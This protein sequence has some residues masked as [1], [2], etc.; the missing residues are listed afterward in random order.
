MKNEENL[1]SEI[2]KNPEKFGLIYDEFYK[3]ILNYVLKRTTNFDLSLDI[4]SEVFLKAFLNIGQFKWKGISIQNWLYRI[5]SN[6]INLFHRSKKYTPKLLNQT[7]PPGQFITFSTDME[8]EKEEAENELIRNTEF[9]QILAIIN[10]LPDKY[11]EVI[12]LKYFEKMNNREI[13]EILGKK[14]GTIKSL[15]SRGLEKIRISYQNA[16]N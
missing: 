16:T 11:K 15:V 3:R 2:K 12:S 8:K 9:I 1:I 7:Y 5:A 14:E 13:G 6:E 10:Q 4:S